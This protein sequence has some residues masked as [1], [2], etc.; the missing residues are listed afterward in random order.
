MTTLATFWG[1][2][3]ERIT[4]VGIAPLMED[5]AANAAALLDAMVLSPALNVT[6][7]FESDSEIFSQS[8]LL[9]SPSNPDALSYAVM[10]LYRNRVAGDRRSTAEDQGILTE[11]R[12][13]AQARSIDFLTEIRPRIRLLQHNLR[14]PCVMMVVDNQILTSVVLHNLPSLGEYWE[15]ARDSSLYKRLSAY[16]EFLESQTGGGL[17]MSLPDQELIQ[18]YD[19]DRIPRGIYPRQAFYN[20]QFKR[21]SIWGLVFNR[22]GEMLIHQRSRTT[23]D[24]RLMWDKSV[25]GHVD[26]GDSSTSQS[27]KRELVE[28]LFLPEAEYTRYVRAD[29]GDIID[30]GEWNLVKRPE[31]AFRA[32]FDGLGSADW[33]LFRATNEAGDPLTEDR[34]SLRRLITDSGLEVKRT[35]FISDVFLFVAP[36]GLMDTHEHMKKLVGLA[37]ETGAAHDHR[38]IT[39]PDLKNWIRQEEDKG[40]AREQFTDDLIYLVT[41]RSELLETF[42]EFVR[43]AFRR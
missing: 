9:D 31:T 14:L 43:K 17:F 42:A 12:T 24:N 27:A 7:Y 13:L 29:L 3:R 34:V 36:L 16:L 19:K 22:N 1:S 11:L 5:L 39:I 25:G 32:A 38:L 15:P 4:I 26:L 18:L 41:E 40:T 23:K 20:T 33:V 21:Y 30:F 2:A 35:I 10:K 8:L 37:E 28:E 6:I